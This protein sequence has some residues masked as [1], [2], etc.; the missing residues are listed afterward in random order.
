[1][2]SP[3]S[4]T[5]GVIARTRAP[6]SV[7]RSPLIRACVARRVGGYAARSSGASETALRMVGAGMTTTLDGQGCRDVNRM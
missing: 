5:P 4:K 1:M 2:A 7:W 6:Q 3:V